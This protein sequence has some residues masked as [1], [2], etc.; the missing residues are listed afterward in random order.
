MYTGRLNLNLVNLDLHGTAMYADSCK[1]IHLD[2][3]P[4]YYSARGGDSCTPAAAQPGVTRPTGRCLLN[5][6]STKFST[7]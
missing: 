4:Q 7:Y 2:A 1:Y 5:L 6:V 3:V